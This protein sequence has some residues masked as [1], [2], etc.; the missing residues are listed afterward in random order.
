MAD[1][2]SIQSAG[3]IQTNFLK[4]LVT[5]LQNQNPLDP[6]DNNQMTSQ[7]TSLS[8]LGQI[9]EL[10]TKFSDV[11]STSQKSYAASLVGREVSFSHTD[12]SGNSQTGIGTVN[13]V[14]TQG[15][16]IGVQVG[17]YTVSLSDILTVI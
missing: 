2:S 8:Q 7:L 1:T 13:G 4:L 14:I 10:N 12:D 15:D 3:D 16:N 9:E 6:M 11:L 5:Q 17:D